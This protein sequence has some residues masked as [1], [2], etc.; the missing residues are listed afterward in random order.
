LIEKVKAI[1]D[2]LNITGFGMC[3]MFQNELFEV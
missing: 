1:F 3:M 2:F